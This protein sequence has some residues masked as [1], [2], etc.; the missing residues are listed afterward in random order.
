MCKR[1]IYSINAN[2]Q[3]ATILMANKDF[4]MGHRLEIKDAMAKADK[5]AF[6]P[7][8]ERDLFQLGPLSMVLPELDPAYQGLLFQDLRVEDPDLEAIMGDNIS[9]EMKVMILTAVKESQANNQLI[10]QLIDTK[11]KSL[12]GW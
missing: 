12:L 9:L 2:C 6:L 11:A 7:V 10:V 8:R 3:T 4:I 5:G 1:L